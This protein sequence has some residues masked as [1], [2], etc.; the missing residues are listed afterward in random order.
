MDNPPSET[1]WGSGGSRSWLV[2]GG[3]ADR[4][5][6]EGGVARVEVGGGIAEADGQGVA[7]AGCQAQ[8]PF[9]TAGAGQVAGV[10]RGDGRGPADACRRL[11]VGVVGSWNDETVDEVAAVQERGL[12]D[13]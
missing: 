9:L 8:Y 1:A 2:A 13:E 7:Q 11:V 3:V 5:A 12:C 6:Q 4:L 10:E